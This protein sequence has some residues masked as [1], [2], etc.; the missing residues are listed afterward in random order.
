[1]FGRRQKA[2]TDEV[3]PFA[4]HLTANQLSQQQ[5]TDINRVLM[6]WWRNKK[7]TEICNH[8]TCT[9][10]EDSFEFAT[11]CFGS[12]SEKQKNEVKKAKRDFDENEIVPNDGSLFQ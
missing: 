9:E 8:N 3:L 2:N 10:N 7:H 1:M 5:P 12:H 6:V 11:S 4:I